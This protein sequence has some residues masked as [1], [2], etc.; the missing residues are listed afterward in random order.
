MFQAENVKKHAA[1]E[2]QSQHELRKL[3]LQIE[4]LESRISPRC[5]VIY[6]DAASPK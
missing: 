2:P 4:P 6:K 1:P 5:I 3:R